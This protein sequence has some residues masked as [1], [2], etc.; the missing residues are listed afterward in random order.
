VLENVGNKLQY[1]HIRHLISASY[2][3]LPNVFIQAVLN[4][5]NISCTTSKVL[6]LSGAC[7]DTGDVISHTSGMIV[8]LCLDRACE[9]ISTAL[10]ITNELIQV[11]YNSIDTK[12][13]TSNLLVI[14]VQ[15][16]MDF[17][18]SNMND[19]FCMVDS[20]ALLDMLR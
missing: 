8:F 2:Q 5:K 19:L 3:A 15:T 14:F 7:I 16:T 6:S 9:A 12:L 18:R 20:I 11:S 17:V 1:Y 13:L 10:N 4:R